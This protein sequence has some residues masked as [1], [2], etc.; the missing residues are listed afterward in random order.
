VLEVVDDRGVAARRPAGSASSLPLNHTRSPRQVRWFFLHE[1]AQLT[2]EQRRFIEALCEDEEV[3]QN[4]RLAQ[5]FDT[6]VR[7]RQ[8]DSLEA[9]MANALATGTRELRGFVDGLRRDWSVVLAGTALPWSNGQTEGVRRVTQLWIS[10]AGGWNWKGGFR[11]TRLTPRRKAMRT[12]AWRES[13]AGTEASRV[14][15]PHDPRPMA[16]A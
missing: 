11:V 9:W 1:S 15:V 7:Q 12:R 6:I 16:R 5:G 13:G 10:P 8:G 2:S 14:L 4:Y 3:A